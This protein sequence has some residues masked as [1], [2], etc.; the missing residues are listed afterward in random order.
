M[1][2]SF[3]AVVDS[4]RNEYFFL[5][6]AK[7]NAFSGGNEDYLAGGFV[8]M[9]ADSMTGGKAAEDYFVVAILLHMGEK[10]PFAAFEAGKALGR[11]IVF[12]YQHDGSSIPIQLEK[13]NR[14]SADYTA[15]ENEISGVKYYGLTGSD[16][17]HQGVKPDA[18]PA[19]GER[20]HSG[21]TARM[22]VADFGGDFQGT[23]GGE[24]VDP[25]Y[26]LCHKL[27]GEH[28]ACSAHYHSVAF[29][30]QGFDEEWFAVSDAE[31]FSLPDG[32]EGDSL[33]VA[34]RLTVFVEDF[35][36]LQAGGVVGSDEGVVI[37]V[38]D[39]ADFLAF[40]LLGYRQAKLSRQLPHLGF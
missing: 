8:A 4:S 36:R 5:A 16:G 26:L 39:K 28:A 1:G 10:L 32:V 12:G 24:A 34:Q 3:G 27:P 19:V 33:M 18:D 7:G 38:G 35:S 31:T 13:D 29:C 22:A 6:V 14:A 40:L 25:V 23:G 21:R 30:I 17:S 2:A 20:G 15:P 9:L 37:I 11:E